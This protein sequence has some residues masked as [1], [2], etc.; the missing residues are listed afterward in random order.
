MSDLLRILDRIG[1]GS[2][3]EA[4]LRSTIHSGYDQ[5]E[6]ELSQYLIRKYGN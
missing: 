1:E 3:P 2:S 5:F 4:A 6:Q